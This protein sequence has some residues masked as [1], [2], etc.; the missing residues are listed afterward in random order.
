M[1]IAKLILIACLFVT[2]GCTLV[3]PK[4]SFSPE[5]VQLVKSAAGS[6]VK[7]GPFS[8]KKGEAEVNQLSL[9]GST[10]VSP[11]NT[12]QDYLRA[13]IEQELI[14]A[15]RVSTTAS[16]EISGFLILNRIDAN[17]ISVGE[18][19][20]AA[21]ILVTREGK[22]RYDK[23]HTASTTWESSFAGAVALPMAVNQYPVLVQK[24]VHTLF[25]D[26]DFVSAIK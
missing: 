16:T 3:A 22:T 6:P 18:G 20:L 25:S 5:N 8:L 17:G 15:K 11:Y 2:S 24:F 26:P 19:E 7:I 23:T 4:Y 12:Y 10:L 14:E 9:R 21:Q 13:A 1:P